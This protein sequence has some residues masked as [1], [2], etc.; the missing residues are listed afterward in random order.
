MSASTENSRENTLASLGMARKTLVKITHR[1]CWPLPKPHVVVDAHSKW[2]EIKMMNKITAS[3]TIDC[4]REI[5]ATHGLPDTIVSDNGPTYTSFEF[6]KFIQGNGIR[7]VF[8]LPYHPASNGLAER[9]VQSFKESMKKLS[10]T[11]SLQHRLAIVLMTQH[12]TPHST[13]GVPPA[14]L[15]MKRQL[16]TTLERI[17]P[18][19]SEKVKEKQEKQK[20]YHDQSAKQRQF[21]I[22][23]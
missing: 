11:L 4:L 22:G 18:N 12:V 8:S 15:L 14:E 10:S 6:Q 21:Q 5:F 3:K 9:A 20:Q 16:T 13:T 2:I 7:H 23:I 1:L 19:L 17:K